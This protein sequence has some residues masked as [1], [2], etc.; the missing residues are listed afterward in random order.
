MRGYTPAPAIAPL[1]PRT[2][3][4]TYM[5]PL[6]KLDLASLGLTRSYTIS[7]NKERELPTQG[8][9]LWTTDLVALRRRAT[10]FLAPTIGLV[11][12]SE[13]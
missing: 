11:L 3:G 12:F 2:G 5:S 10:A 7:I 9:G 13:P 6:A 8:A 4:N 1:A